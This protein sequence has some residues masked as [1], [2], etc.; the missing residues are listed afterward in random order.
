ML[1]EDDLDRYR[2]ALLTWHPSA[3][4]PSC[5]HEVES[6]N[7]LILVEWAIFGRAGQRDPCL[8]FKTFLRGQASRGNECRPTSKDKG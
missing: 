6:L 3:D 8:R 4:P 7:P 2:G 1:P 5:S